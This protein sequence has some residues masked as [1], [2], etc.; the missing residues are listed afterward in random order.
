MILNNDSPSCHDGEEKVIIAL[1]AMGGDNAPDAVIKGAS[2]IAKDKKSF[3]NIFL[4][5]YGNQKDI[6]HL[7]ESNPDLSNISELIHCT[8]AIPADETISAAIRNYKDSSMSLAIHNVKEK[9]AQAVVSA[10]NTA[11]LMAI[12]T[13]TLKTL[14]HIH[15]PAIVAV[16]PSATGKITMLDVG[17]NTICNANNLYQFAVMGH[18]FAKILLNISYP[19]IG[20][21][22]IGS[23][24]SKG[25]D[26]I[27]LA[28]NMIEQ[29]LLAKNFHGYVE[30]NDI[31]LGTVDVAVADG[32]TGNAL[33]K[34]IGGY[35]KLYKSL[36]KQAIT[37]NLFSKLKYKLLFENEFTKMSSALD[38][39]YYN[40]A[41]LIGLNGI[42][43]KSHGSMDD[44]GI[45]NAIKTA[46]K[47]AR[48]NI[49]KE[50]L[51]ELKEIQPELENA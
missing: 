25:I 10:G 34:S 49:N 51:E 35:G 8:Q 2:L 3:P 33:L 13:L 17:A 24:E 45:A 18:A 21:L 5:I 39:R 9:Q 7:I 46:Y 31:A 1:D 48:F 22:N 40:G 16:L 23:E 26:S 38:N 50:I 29:S 20:L 6:K 44:I 42:V 30:G 11:A 47:L 43:V 27:K 28:K 37:Q 14:P 36:I 19:R 15:R 4:R 12:S 32:F 41:M